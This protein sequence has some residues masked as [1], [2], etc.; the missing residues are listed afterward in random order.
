MQVETPLCAAALARPRPFAATHRDLGGKPSSG[1]QLFLLG[2]C[3]ATLYCPRAVAQPADAKLQSY[4]REYLDASFA[5]RP[6]MATEMGDH[7][8]DRQLGDLSAEARERWIEHLRGT[9]DELPRRIDYAALSGAGQVDF[10]MWKQDLERD[11]WLADNLAP[12]ETDPRIYNRYL[13]DSVYLLLAQSTLPRKPTFPT[14]S[15]A[16]SSF[17]T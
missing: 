10:D 4:F 7:R 15:P 13:N 16:W 3:L 5:M 2:I 11:L 8:F 17:Q 1:L 14:P 6:L 9:L 12:W